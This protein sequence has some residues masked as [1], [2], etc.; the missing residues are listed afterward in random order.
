M[1][2]SSRFPLAPLL[3][4]AVFLTLGAGCSGGSPVC[5]QDTPCTDAGGADGRVR[6]P[7]ATDRLSLALDPAGP[8]L[9]A[10]GGAHPTVAFTA[11]G[12][13][14]DGRTRR[15]TGAAMRFSV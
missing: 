9:D 14:R 15:L 12:I 10:S 6:Q 13:Q 3:V 4:A 11:L 5:G 8:V 1:P 7:L 2:A